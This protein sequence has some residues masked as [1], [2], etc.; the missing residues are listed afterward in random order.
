M[1]SLVETAKENG[2]NPYDYLVWVLKAAPEMELSQ[3]PELAEQL[4][5]ER[6][7]ASGTGI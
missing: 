4:V 6:F 2:I 3:N 1:Y 5:P 7:L